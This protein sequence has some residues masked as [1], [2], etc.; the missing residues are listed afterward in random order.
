MRIVAYLYS[1]PLLDSPPQPEWEVDI[2]RV[3][4]DL[5]DRHAWQQLIKDCQDPPDCLLIRR[6]EELGDTPQ[7]VGDRLAQLEAF[8]IEIIAT[9]QSYRSSGLDDAN[10]T[11][12]RA[13]L[14][15]ILQELEH[16]QRRRRLRQGHARNRLKALPPP[17]KAPYGYR[18]GKERYILDRSTA[19]VVKDFFERFLLFGSLRGQYAI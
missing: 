14:I 3:Y 16:S 9:E 2:E 5:G 15:Q 19:P 4:Q 18:R 17:G 1:D 10:P 11:E 13:Y 12:A 8:G 7:Q 6:L